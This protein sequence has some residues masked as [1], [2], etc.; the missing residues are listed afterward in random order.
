MYMLW[1]CV[2]LSVRPSQ[3]AIVSKGL[4]ESSWFLTWRLPSTYPTLWRKFWYLR[5]SFV[6]LS[7]TSDLENFVTANRWCCQLN[8][9]SSSSSTVDLVDDT[10]SLYDNRR[11]L[12]VAVNR[13]HLAA[14][15]ICCIRLVSTVDKILTDIARRAVRLR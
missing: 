15:W 7:Q 9:S 13:N 1:S 2:S 14:S 5:N 10:Y 4:D 6:T 8:S 12:A 11:V 3:A